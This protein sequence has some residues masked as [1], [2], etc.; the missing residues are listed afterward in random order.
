MP[1]FFKIALI[2]VVCLFIIA[3]AR[4]LLIKTVIEITASNMLGAKTQVRS[5]S[6]SLIKQS[7]RIKGLEIYNPKGFGNSSLLDVK[8]V[9]ADL[10]FA[11]LLKGKIR[12]SKV[13][14]SLN[15]IEVIRNKN[16]ELNVDALKVSQK[17]ESEQKK[18]TVVKKQGFE[19]DYLILNVGKLVFKDYGQGK[20][21]ISVY[22]S[23]IQNK[24]YKNIKGAEQLVS[25]IL[26]E[27][28]KPLALKSA[29][30]YG[31]STLAGVAFL[32]LAAATIFSGKDSAESVFEFKFDDVFNRSVEAL[33]TMGKI[34]SSN[35]NSGVIEAEIGGNSVKVIISKT[36]NKKTKVVAK[37]SKFMLPK[38]E[39]SAGVIYKITEL[40]K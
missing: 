24:A 19:I 37:A 6:M 10:D 8:T 14:L 32:P 11:S 30:T 5:F 20:E 38:P 22:E 2:I 40:V 18:K 29:L 1:K 28:M 12:L 17:K 31:A 25:L 9:F 36:S 39:I 15:K 27:S 35:R 3:L 26:I 34:S 33:G 7:V 4:D 23:I 16:G 13:E 21:Q